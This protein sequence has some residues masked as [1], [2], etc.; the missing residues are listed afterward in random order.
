MPHTAEPSIWRQGQCLL[1][2]AIF[3]TLQGLQIA[4]RMQSAIL[5]A[6]LTCLAW[7]G[8]A[9]VFWLGGDWG[10]RPVAVLGA[11]GRKKPKPLR[12][13]S[14]PCW[15]N[16]PGHTWDIAQ[17]LFL[18]F[19]S[20]GIL[21]LEGGGDAEIAGDW[22]ARNG[23]LGVPDQWEPGFFWGGLRPW[24]AFHRGGA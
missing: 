12:M 16:G 18:G 7:W 21:Q 19:A 1:F 23:A 5:M 17:S 6:A 11:G 4:A 24:A 3:L 9:S 2:S 13:D 8:T 15:C 14:V 22:E 10:D 20:E